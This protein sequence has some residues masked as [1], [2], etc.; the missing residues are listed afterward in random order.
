MILLGINFLGKIE[1]S[2]ILEQTKM[3]IKKMRPGVFFY[4][5]PIGIYRK[6]IN[7]LQVMYYIKFFPKKNMGHHINDLSDVTID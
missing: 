4:P 5:G 7:I 2:Y 1:C 3:S 6:T